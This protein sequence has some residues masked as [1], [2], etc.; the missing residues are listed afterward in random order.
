MVRLSSVKFVISL[1]TRASTMNTRCAYTTHQLDDSRGGTVRIN[2]KPPNSSGKIGRQGHRAWLIQ[3]RVLGLVLSP[4]SFMF[5]IDV[6]DNS[7]NSPLGATVLIARSV[8]VL[9]RTS[10]QAERPVLHPKG[11]TFII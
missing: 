4:T 9:Q 3:T 7:R 2:S 10:T 11:P 5:G 1:R 6:R 8:N